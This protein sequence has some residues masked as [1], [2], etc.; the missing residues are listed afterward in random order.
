MW[1]L[2]S[3]KILFYI[4]IT[5]ARSDQNF[6]NYRGGYYNEFYGNYN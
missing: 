3:R 1:G 6:K 2:L 5:K 4:G